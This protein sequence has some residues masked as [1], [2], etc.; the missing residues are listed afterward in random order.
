MLAHRFVVMTLFAG[1]LLARGP[2]PS[3]A[4][5]ARP[6]FPGARVEIYKTIG[7]VSLDIHIFEPEG[8]RPSD[9]RPAIVFFFGGGWR[10]GQ[11]RQFEQQCRYLAS[12][13]MV[14]MTADYRVSSR[15][16]TQVKECVQD[17]KSAIRW[18]RTHAA[19]LGIDPDRIAAGG[20]SAGGHLAA[21]T[22]L[23]HGFEEPGEP[24]DVSS[25]PNALVLFNPAI[26][27]GPFEG[28]RPRNDDRAA[29]LPERM[30]TDPVNLSPAH[31][32]R[33]GLPP[34]IQ[35]FGTDDPLLEGARYFHQQMEEAGNRSEL[36][37][38]RG[39]GH[40]FFNYGRGDNARFRETLAAAD[41]F[42]GSLGY[43]EGPPRVN[44]W[45]TETHPP[46]R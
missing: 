7:P 20:G 26:A 40:G 18:V 15:H 1:A 22:A 38:Y 16:H 2:V 25:A 30:G 5:D 29:A 32:V 33:P 12:R 4:A 24:T 44:D 23:I 31:H 39:Q 43:L 42:L 11:P 8:H 46:R 27:L 19:R 3:D 45:W 36:L 9:R 35:F 41:R 34:T 37:T 14:A 28:M 6:T 13:G 17:A 21:C 10:S